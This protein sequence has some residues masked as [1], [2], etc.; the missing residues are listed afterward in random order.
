[1]NILDLLIL[2]VL[3][4]VFFYYCHKKK[5]LFFRRKGNG[6]AD[7]GD[8]D[9]RKADF[10]P[11]APPVSPAAPLPPYPYP[12]GYIYGGQAGIPAGQ[13]VQGVQGGTQNSQGSITL[14]RLIPWTFRCN[15]L[16]FAD[17]GEKAAT[18]DDA[19]N[20]DIVPLGATLD[21]EIRSLNADGYT[22]SAISVVSLPLGD[23]AVRALFCITCTGG[24]KR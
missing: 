5:K 4:A 18:A 6:G 21:G 17:P 2:V 16:P 20:A 22:V 24:D 13:N 7:S 15:P 8:R 19:V 3:V 12:Y 23:G 9:S 14:C 1:M 11:A 10:A